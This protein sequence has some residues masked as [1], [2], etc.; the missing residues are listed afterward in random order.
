VEVTRTI[1]LKLEMPLGVAREL[2]D[3]Y[4]MACNFASVTAFTMKSRAFAG[5]NRAVYSEVRERYKLSAQITQS[6]S[7]IVAARY[8][9]M[10]S[11][12]KKPKSAIRFNGEP[13]LLQGGDRQRD[14]GFTKDLLSIST[15]SGRMKYEYAHHPHLESYRREWKLGGAYLFIRNNQVFLAVSYSREVEAQTVP[16]DSVIG[17]DRGLNYIAVATSDKRALF[18]GG[19]QVRQRRAH[20]LKTRASLQTRKAQKPTRSVRRAW[21]RLRGKEQR[22]GRDVDHVTSKRIVDFAASTG[23]A[24]IALENLEGIRCGAGTGKRTKNFNNRLHRWSFYRLSECVEYKAQQRGMA[25]IYVDAKYT[26]Q[27][28]SKCGHTEKANRSG[29]A[30]SCKACGYSLHSDLQAARNIRLRGILSR[31]VLA[32]DGVPS[33]T[34]K[35][36]SAASS[37]QTPG[38]IQG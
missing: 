26:S 18:V 34:P 32:E 28:C 7:R 33:I 12:K 8:A 19:G 35:V 4:T 21:K 29:H 38:F 3:A 23:N 11:N 37:G 15:L 13:V 5:L 27:G 10:K 16:H 17:V 20:Y 31:Q 25:V 9:S 6:V 36:R 24:V 22:F 30:F 1:T 14:F 2:I